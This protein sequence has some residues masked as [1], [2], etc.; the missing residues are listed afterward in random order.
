VIT[1]LV[2][3]ERSDEVDNEW[4]RVMTTED[5]DEHERSEWR[6]DESRG[7]VGDDDDLI[8]VE[9]CQRRGS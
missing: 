3:K 9:E 2:T 7:G 8:K 1:K 5:D 6:L 4:Q